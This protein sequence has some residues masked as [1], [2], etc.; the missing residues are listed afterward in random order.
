MVERDETGR[1][2]SARVDLGLASVQAIHAKGDR[3]PAPP[4]RRLPEGSMSTSDQPGGPS[5]VVLDIPTLA[6]KCS[7]L[8]RPRLCAIWA[9][10]N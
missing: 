5:V 2:V 1:G 10:K 6:T 8:L 7:S 3:R 4:I 9:P